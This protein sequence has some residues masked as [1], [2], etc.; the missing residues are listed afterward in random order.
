[1]R[2]QDRAAFDY[3][4]YLQNFETDRLNLA[5]PNRSGGAWLRLPGVK[6]PADVLERL[7]HANAEKLV[8]GLA[9]K[10]TKP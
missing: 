9:V 7:Y 4:Q 3:T 8:P 6:L 2:W 1:M 5:D 10:G